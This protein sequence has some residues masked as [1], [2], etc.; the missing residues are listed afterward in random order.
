MDKQKLKQAIEFAKQNPDSEYANELRKRIESGQIVIEKEQPSYLQRVGEQ[1]GNIAER[2]TGALKKSGEGYLEK[3]QQGDVLGATGEL[4][5]SGLRSVGAVAE[6]AFAPITEAPGI[7][8]ALDFIGEKLGNTEIGQKLAQKM[9][10]NP[11][12]AQDIM[13][14]IILQQTLVK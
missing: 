6:G 4:L 10:E 9:Q 12:K 14:I 3:A 8:Q 11:E 5:R 1:Y 7:K 13:D 2:T